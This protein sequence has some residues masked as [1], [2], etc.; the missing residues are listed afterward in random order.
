[1]SDYSEI[2]EDIW[3]RVDYIAP[4]L[5]RIGKKYERD[6]AARELPVSVVESTKEVQMWMKYPDTFTLEVYEPLN[7]VVH[8][9]DVQV[10]TGSE[11]VVV[12]YR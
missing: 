4:Y 11:N 2:P 12:V 5:M 7:V 10:R 6:V 8:L 9:Q 3:Y 1:M